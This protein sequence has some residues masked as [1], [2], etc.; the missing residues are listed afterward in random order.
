MRRKKENRLRAGI[1]QTQN[2]IY[3]PNNHQ[4]ALPGPNF[5]PCKFDKEHGL[6]NMAGNIFLLGMVV[7]INEILDYVAAQSLDFVLAPCMGNALTD[8]LA[9]SVSQ[10]EAESESTVPLTEAEIDT[11]SVFGL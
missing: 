2:I 10:D 4:N 11:D 8:N 7:V 3:Q 6:I 1:V 5:G 9:Y